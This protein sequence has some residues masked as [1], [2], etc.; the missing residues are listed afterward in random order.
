[1]KVRW[2]W[3]IVV[4]VVV[5]GL[6][7]A[8]DSGYKPDQKWVAPAEAVSKKNPLAANPDA[9]AGGKKL[10]LRSCAECHNEDGTGLQKAANLTIPEVQ[11]E[12]DGALFWKISNG[13]VRK[14]MPSFSR[15]PEM[16]RWQLILFI[17]SLKS[18]D[19]SSSDAQA[20][21]H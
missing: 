13:H 10:F 17:R 1:M 19:Q 7:R 14:G 4:L 20:K 2:Q 9:A 6:A 16:Q 18:A 3:S 11:A 12:T 5:L 8:Q 21:E 15:L